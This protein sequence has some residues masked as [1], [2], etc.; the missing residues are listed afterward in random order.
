MTAPTTTTSDSDRCLN[1]CHNNVVTTRSGSLST[2]LWR[3]P[4]LPPNFLPAQTPSTPGIPRISSQSSIP[5]YL[6]EFSNGNSYSENSASD[7]T[8]DIIDKVFAVLES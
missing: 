7:K 5:P 3:L 8:I 2:V 6:F 1:A 4:P